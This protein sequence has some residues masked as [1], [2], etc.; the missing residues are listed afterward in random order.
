MSV[1]QVE[2]M[3][4]I[5]KL[6]H[7]FEDT[8]IYS[9]LQ[10]YMG[11][12]YTTRLQSPTN[13]AIKVGGFCFFVGNVDIE[14]LTFVA[15]EYTIL[16]PLGWYWQEAIEKIY[17]KA[18]RRTRYA[19]KKEKDIFDTVY[20]KSIVQDLD[21]KYLLRQIDENIYAKIVTMSWAKDL[22]INYKDYHEYSKLGLGFVIFDNEDI[23]AGASSY[24]RYK[25]GI[26]IQIDTK[27]EHRKKGLALVCAAKL[28]LECMNRKWYPSWD[29]HNL[30]SL[31][32]AKKLGYHYDKEYVVY[33]LG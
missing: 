26:E 28:I 31:A 21:Q 12:A 20:L 15:N 29:A 5:V 16:I 17:P 19:L 25:E 24:T 30:G 18:K 27:R 10:G 23:V 11:E 22:C 4:T 9:C 32:L 13:A 6:F 8:M 1:Y 3:E 2:N 14:L 7:G 33:K